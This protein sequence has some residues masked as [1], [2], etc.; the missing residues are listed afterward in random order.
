MLEKPEP[1][2]KEL[3]DEGPN[4]YG[5]ESRFCSGYDGMSLLFKKRR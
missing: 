4:G 1:K 2:G 5:K 3:D